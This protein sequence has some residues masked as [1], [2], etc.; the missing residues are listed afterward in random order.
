MRAFVNGSIGLPFRSAGVLTRGDRIAAVAADDEIRA[1]AKEEGAEIVD[2][3]G[4]TLLPGFQDA[5]VHLYLAGQHGSRLDL[6]ATRSISAVL[7]EIRAFAGRSTGAVLYA[8]GLDETI[9][10]EKRFPTLEEL[11]GAIDDRPLVVF[12]ICRHVGFL[13]R[14]ALKRVPSTFDHVDRACGRIEEQSLFGLEKEVFVPTREERRSWIRLG[15]EK[16]FSLGITTVHEIKGPGVAEAYRSLATDGTLRMRVFYFLYGDWEHALRLREQFRDLPIHFGGYKIFADGTIGAETAAV[17]EPYSNG[18]RGTL[19]WEG[20]KLRA[21][22][23]A[24]ADAS[25]P[26]MCHAIG[27]RA[28]DQLLAVRLEAG[29]DIPFLRMEHVEMLRQESLSSVVRGGWRLCPQPNFAHQWQG[30]GGL[31]ENRLGEAR[32]RAMNRSRSWSDAGVPLA[33]GSD[34]MPMDP[35]YGVRAAT[36]HPNPDERFGWEEAFS[37]YSRSAEGFVAGGGDAGV[38]E[39]GKRADL[40]WVRLPPEEM[41]TMRAE[42]IRLT[43][44][45]GEVVHER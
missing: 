5:H 27:D 39:E 32:A 36:E 12:R 10:E 19:F 45:G 11:S 34:G 30:A 16:A 13:N 25:M 2:L 38:I 42:D 8:Y 33:F 7:R 44:A 14:C 15:E 20:D 41:H 3:A 6:G 9:L 35:V 17:H 1:L 31:Y 4:G 24:A 23:I 28:I 43:I 26:L 22:F 29:G 40:N 37:L 21:L 18:G